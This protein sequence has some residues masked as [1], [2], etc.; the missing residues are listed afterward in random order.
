MTGVENSVGN[1]SAAVGA[2]NLVGIGLYGTFA[3][4]GPLAEGS[5]AKLKKSRL[6]VCTVYDVL[7]SPLWLKLVQVWPIISVS[8]W[9]LTTVTSVPVAN[10]IVWARRGSRVNLSP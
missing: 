8:S 5:A 9:Y 6:I 4:C 10:G 1:L 3:D 2:R 7:F